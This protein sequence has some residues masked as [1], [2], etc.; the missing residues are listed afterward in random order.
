M[1]KMKTVFIVMNVKRERCVREEDWLVVNTTETWPC[2]LLMGRNLVVRVFVLK[3]KDRRWY[4]LKDEWAKTDPLSRIRKVLGQ[5][6][7]LLSDWRER[8][9]E[10]GSGTGRLANLV[11]GVWGNFYSILSNFS[12]NSLFKWKLRPKDQKFEKENLKRVLRK[13]KEKTN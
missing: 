12:V 11:G 7:H 4:S 9:Q 6:E 8:R 3:R 10:K 5:E 2:K 13:L 1:R